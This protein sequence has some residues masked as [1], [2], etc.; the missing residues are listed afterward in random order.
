MV[1]ADSIVA[2]AVAAG[3]ASGRAADR[4][5]LGASA[6]IFAAG[7]AVTIHCCGSMSAMGGMPMPG[8]WTM[9]MAWMR[10]PGQTWPAAAAS[11]LGMWDVMMVAM[12]LP[13][14]VPMLL[15]YRQAVFG[16]G[17]AGLG[18][19]TVLVSVGYFAIWTVIGMAVFLAGVALAAVATQQPALARG[20]P[21]ATAVVVVVAG[22]LQFSPWKPRQLGCC[23]DTPGRG[24][25]LPADAASAWRHGLGL[26]LSCGR[27][28]AGLMAILV[29]TGVMDLRVMA[30]VTAAITAERVAPAGE[31][32]A[33]VTGAVVVAAGL[34]L[35][36]RAAGLV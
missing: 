32:V 22:T 3:G 19:L 1:V 27:C 36:T 15:R 8:G 20:L 34:A 24:R 11:F 6:L 33:R 35:I 26:G 10:M 2:R 13:S 23:R 16:T 31:R 25:A 18:R 12:M 30:G 14:L 29:V 9:S 17:V 4:V 7:A 28:C 5:F 21:M